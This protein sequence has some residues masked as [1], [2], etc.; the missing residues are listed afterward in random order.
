MIVKEMADFQS[1][2]SLFLSSDRVWR[3][4]EWQWVNWVA[5]SLSHAVSKWASH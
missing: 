3:S 4:E 2:V 5:G 1:R